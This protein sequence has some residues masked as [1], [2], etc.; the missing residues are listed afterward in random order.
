MTTAA[1]NCASPE[2]PWASPEDTCASSI[3]RA[4]SSGRPRS[5]RSADGKC[6]G[7][8][9]AGLW[10]TT[11]VF[12]FTRAANSTMGAASGPAPSTSSFG[13]KL[14][15]RAKSFHDGELPSTQPSRPVRAASTSA[16]CTLVP[17]RDPRT[18]ADSV[19]GNADG[20]D[21]PEGNVTAPIG[22]SGQVDSRTIPTA[23]GDRLS[24]DRARCV[25]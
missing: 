10:S 18:S 22:N 13:G 14:K 19:A 7:S 8:A 1:E 20:D 24:R 5:T 21:A 3:V 6:D 9:Y 17:D 15:G 2:D 12:Q 25:N 16:A 11:V 23:V 4:S